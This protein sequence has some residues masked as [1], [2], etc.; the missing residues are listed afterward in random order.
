MPNEQ[1]ALT[2]LKTVADNSAE[3]HNCLLVFVQYVCL[4]CDQQGVCAQEKQ[5]CTFV[6][7]LTRHKVC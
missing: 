7:P 6:C 4:I 5:A 2:I 3:F 1:D